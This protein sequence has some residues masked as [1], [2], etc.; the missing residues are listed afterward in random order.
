M[1]NQIKT[2]ICNLIN[3][4]GQ[5]PVTQAVQVVQAIILEVGLLSGIHAVSPTCMLNPWSEDSIN[6]GVI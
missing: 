3:M 1:T 6:L 5:S 4:Q 2:G